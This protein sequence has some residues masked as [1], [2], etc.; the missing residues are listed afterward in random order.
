MII[1]WREIF[2]GVASFANVVL[3]NVELVPANCIIPMSTYA[4][5]LL[6]VMFIP[7]GLLLPALFYVGELVYYYYKGRDL[8]HTI[9]GVIKKC[10]LLTL[11]I[12]YYHF[13]P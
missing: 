13:F 6:Y 9:R 3:M 1:D 4:R 12:I 7:I 2:D 8:R 11:F 10:I 5:F